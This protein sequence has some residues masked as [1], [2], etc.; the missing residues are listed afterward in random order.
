VDGVE[1]VEQSALSSQ[2]SAWGRLWND[3]IPKHQV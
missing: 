2:H 3:V 1:A